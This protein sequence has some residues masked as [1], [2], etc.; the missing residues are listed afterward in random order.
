LSVPAATQLPSK[1]RLKPAVLD[2]MPEG[3]TERVSG[4]VAQAIPRSLILFLGAVT[5]VRLVAA[6]M[7][8]LTEDEAY[9]RLWAQHVRLG[10]LDHPPM[11]AWWIHAGEFIAGDTSL[12]VRL[13]PILGCAIVSLLVFDLAKTLSISSRIAERGAIWFQAMLMIALGGI[14]ATPDSPATLF[15]I[16]TLCCV[17][18]AQN[19]GR[20]QWWLAAGAAAGLGLLSKYS[21]FFLAPGILLTLLARKEGRAALRGPWPWLAAVVAM[22]VFAPNFV[23]NAAHHWQT[24]EKQFGRARFVRFEPR[25]IVELALGQLLLIN[26]LIMPF[27]FKGIRRAAGRLSSRSV[28][29]ALP[30][31][32]TIPFAAYLLVHALHDRVQA[33]WPTPLYPALALLA[34]WGSRDIQSGWLKKTAAAA[35]PVGLALGLICQAHLA[36]PVTDIAGLNDPSVM[37]RGWPGFASKVER[38]RRRLGATWIATASYATTAELDDQRTLSGP[39]IQLDERDRYPWSDASRIVGRPDVG[40]VID[41]TRRLSERAL[42]RCFGSVTPLGMI[43]RS[44]PRSAK[45]QYAAF[46]VRQPKF[47]ARLGCSDLANRHIPARA[48]AAAHTDGSETAGV[49]RSPLMLTPPTGLR[50]TPKQKKALRES[51]AGIGRTTPSR[52]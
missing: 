26:P 42:G 17:A 23:W 11:I 21:G 13:V 16:A 52:S 33:H 44:S 38:L 30:L 41:V 27:V 49:A 40:I 35:A 37:V 51:G 20:A 32:T 14:L 8:P 6:A 5:L 2:Q 7:I 36:L 19:G 39:V 12:G 50:R 22:A 24:F 9:Y 10:Y 25:Y 34:A 46:E 1:T 45:V 31:A 48:S 43:E 29:L 15:W 18:R 47:N 28:D 4:S 3:V